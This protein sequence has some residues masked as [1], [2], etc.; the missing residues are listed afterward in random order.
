[1]KNVTI[2]L[3]EKVLKWAR[4]WAARHNSS[5]SRLVGEM[6]RQRMVE[7]EGYKALMKQHLSSK[8]EKL[9]K[10]G[11]YPSRDELHEGIIITNP[12]YTQPDKILP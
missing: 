4:I 9:K 11:R 3:D 7:E 1:M 10:T 5:V 6:L 2:T 8:P 12:F